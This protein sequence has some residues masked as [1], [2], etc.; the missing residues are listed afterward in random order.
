MKKKERVFTDWYGNPI[1]SE[2]G[3]GICTSSPNLFFKGEVEIDGTKYIRA[4]NRNG[5]PGDRIALEDIYLCIKDESTGKVVYDSRQAPPP[6][7]NLQPSYI[8]YERDS[9]LKR[10]FP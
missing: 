7:A 3:V 8:G 4:Y 1:S 9:I 5:V 10:Y 2:R 6:D